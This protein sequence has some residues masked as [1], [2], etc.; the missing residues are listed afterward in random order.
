MLGA[1][2]DFL[3]PMVIVMLPGANRTWA[4]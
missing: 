4:A 2:A 3:S 1:F